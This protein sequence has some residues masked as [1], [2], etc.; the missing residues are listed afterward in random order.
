MA[1]PSVPSFY[2]GLCLI[3][4]GTGLLKPNVSAIVGDL[5]PEG[6]ARRD[7]GFSIFYIGINTGAF[8]GPIICGFLGERINWHVGFGAA[9]IGMVLGLIQYRFGGRYLGEAGLRRSEGNRR[10]PGAGRVD[11][12]SAVS[13]PWRPSFWCSS[14]CGPRAS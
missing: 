12:S 7:A 13:E 14:V 5:Y 8:L 9:G 10:T 6:G 1:L 11:A 4:C 2:F 3:A